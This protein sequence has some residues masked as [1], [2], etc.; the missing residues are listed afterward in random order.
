MLTHREIKNLVN[1]KSLQM[2]HQIDKLS[3]F[4]NRKSSP[5][6]EAKLIA[7]SHSHVSKILFTKVLFKCGAIIARIITGFTINFCDQPPSS[8]YS[9]DRPIERK[10]TVYSLQSMKLHSKEKK[11]SLQDVAS[12]NETV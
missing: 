3:G 5:S 7:S 2:P 6:P 12:I 4:G 9:P 1:S 11:S 8:L 10:I